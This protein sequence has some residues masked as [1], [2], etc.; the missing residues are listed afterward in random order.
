M[1]TKLFVNSIT[2]TFKIRRFMAHS[3][4]PGKQL[5]QVSILSI[6]QVNSSSPDIHF[7]FICIV[8]LTYD[9]TMIQGHYT[10]LGHYQLC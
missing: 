2:L 1:E 9:M 8:T 7:G 4:Y 6:L 3:F 10:P 5:C